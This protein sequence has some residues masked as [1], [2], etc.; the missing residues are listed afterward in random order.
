MQVA[1]SKPPRTK[2]FN[3]GGSS[4]S[5]ERLSVDLRD[6]TKADV[7]AM[8]RSIAANET[9]QQTALDNPPSI[10]EVD[11]SKSK[12]ASQAIR[13]V[14]VLFGVQLNTAV[15]AKVTDMLITNIQSSTE[16][17]TGRLSDPSSWEWRHIRNGRRVPITGESISF[18]PRDFLTLR[19]RLAYASAVNK[20]V[21]SG[22]RSLNYYAMNAKSTARA[23]RTAKRNQQ[24]GFMAMT[25]RQCREIPEL[26]QFS[27]IVGHTMA[28]AVE[29]EVRKIG[30]TAYLLIAPRRR[31]GFRR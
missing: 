2:T 14:I 13:K 23:T 10:T 9:A 3:V 28:Y 17:I 4:V 27:V 5:T 18:G 26:V 8:L 20:R 1:L 16:P 31:R 21:A 25:A 11:N 7:I 24:L 12:P 30:G 15:L 6:V 22:S 29:G 19:P